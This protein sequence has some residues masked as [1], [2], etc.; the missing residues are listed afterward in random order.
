MDF[1]NTGDDRQS[2]PKT[3]SWNPFDLTKVWPHGD[4]PLIDVGV[5]EL[6]EIPKNYFAMWSNLL[7]HLHML[8]MASVI[9]LIKCCRAD[10]FLIPMHIAIVWV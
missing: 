4:F 2:K 6:N 1:E 7:L 8:W 3:F 10:Y 5:M 9:H